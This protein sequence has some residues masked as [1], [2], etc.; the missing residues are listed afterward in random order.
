MTKARISQTMENQGT[1]EQAVWNGAGGR[2]EPRSSCDGLNL[3]HHLFLLAGLLNFSFCLSMLLSD[4][5]TKIPQAGL[6]LPVCV[7]VPPCPSS[8]ERNP[9]WEGRENS[10]QTGLGV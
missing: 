4:Q 7:S 3:I 9:E 10:S 6:A 8:Q 1:K 2:K 5:K